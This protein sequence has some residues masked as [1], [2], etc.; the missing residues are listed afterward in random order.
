VLKKVTLMMDNTDPTTWTDH[1]VED[2]CAFLSTK[3]ETFPES[4]R[5][6]HG[7]VSALTDVTPAPNKQ[8]IDALQALP[9]PFYVVVYPAGPVGWAIGIGLVL[10]AAT[11]FLIPTPDIPTAAPALA[12]NSQAPSPNNELS[13]RTNQARINGRIPDIYGTVRSTPDLIAAPYKIFEANREIE[14]AYMCVGRGAYVINAADIRDGETKVEDIPG[15]SVM[16]YA[17]YTSPNS[18]DPN[19]PANTS[20][21][22]TVGEFVQVPVLNTKRSNSINGQV[23][24]PP[25]AGLFTADGNVRFRYPNIIELQ[26]GSPLNFTQEF[27]PGA[28]LTITDGDMSTLDTTESTVSCRAVNNVDLVQ[29]YPGGSH[30]WNTIGG[31]LVFEGADS[32]FLSSVFVDGDPVVISSNSVTSV[33]D[34]NG[35][36]EVTAFEIDG[37]DN[38]L[39]AS[40]SVPTYLV[41]RLLNPE[42]INATWNNAAFES[43]TFWNGV[44]YNV[45]VTF[46]PPFNIN[47]NGAY[48]I[49]AV[50]QTQ[51]LLDNPSAVAS[52]WETVLSVE[53][54]TPYLSPTLSSSGTTW[55]GPYI[56]E[57]PDLIEIYCNFVAQNGLY[58]DSGTTQTA[59]VV[60]I[61]FEATPVDANDDPIGD[62]ETWTFTLTGSNTLKETVAATLKAHPASFYGR[63]SVRARRTTPADTA[64]TGTVVDEVRWRDVYSV[65]FVDATD[66]GNVTTVMSVTFATASALA[67]KDRKLNMIVQRKLPSWDGSEWSAELTGT[68]D[69][70]T[71][72]GAICRDQYIGNRSADEIDVQNFFDTADEVE[73]YFGTPR[74]RRF[75]YTFDKD[76]L[77][78]EEMVSSVAKAM[79][80]VAYRQGRLIR[81]SF[82][83]ETDNSTLL[84]NHRNK[85]PGTERRTITFG[86]NQ[87][88]DGLQ[89]TYVD[90]TDDS[91]NTIFLPL[92]YAARNPKK[93]ESIGIRSHLHAYFHAWRAW[94]RIR[95]Q[96]TVAEF[97]A[98]QE[99]DLLVINDRILVSD[100]TRPVMQEGD[101][102]EVDG[103]TLTLSQNVDLTG[104]PPY[105]IFLQLYDGTVESIAITAG[106]E[107]N[108]VI[109]GSAP[110]L[111]LVTGSEMTA[112]TT[113]IIVGANESAQRAFL[114]AE[115]SPSGK[116]T[117]KVRGV[118]YDARYYGNDLD[119]INDLVEDDGLG[120][121]GGFYPGTGN[122]FPDTAVTPADVLDGDDVFSTLSSFEVPIV[123]TLADSDSA[124]LVV[125][126]LQRR[127]NTTAPTSITLGGVAPLAL[128]HRHGA[129]NSGNGTGV[130]SHMAVA[131]FPLVGSAYDG[132]VAISWAGNTGTQRAHAIAVKNVAQTEPVMVATVNNTNQFFLTAST[133][134]NGAL[135]VAAAGLM[136]MDFGYELAKDGVYLPSADSISIGSAGA[137]LNGGVSFEESTVTASGIAIEHSDGNFGDFVDMRP[138]FALTFSPA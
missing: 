29:T 3:F 56:L 43:P 135:I 47:L 64:F 76:N 72:L 95:Y 86:A 5:I 57:D 50:T 28:I 9:G 19:D 31:A 16:V 52:D 81:L 42:S 51:I 22:L 75:M 82:E 12:R 124:Y 44:F 59:A 97:E 73:T 130:Y 66:F 121:T 13:N 69:A 88:N 128:Y 112:R 77:S 54:A 46:T 123:E 24:R 134:A 60:D 87:D 90:P 126:V 107:Q 38:A 94:N 118:N 109:L 102:L 138:G 104:D 120:R 41:V 98:T 23:L 63:C 133:V 36:Y 32:E 37:P 119:F 65:S 40:Y 70:A 8:S 103:T 21:E 136:N 10:G 2:L 68:D 55:V 79:F 129:P 117:S 35:T 20:P 71:I 45:T 106:S 93:I 33:G 83:K 30:T 105:S 100:N 96:N 92:E 6:F 91:V 4:A 34:I 122:G 18:Y 48:T 89:Y 58:K 125:T 62:P 101:V 115:K 53:E 26:E 11:Y 49:L 116:M 113:Y 78:F 108:E 61:E 25:S 67:V 131:V 137:F 80:C 111:S 110:S 39:E 85:L 14:Y 127:T 7:V 1:E 27:Q 74:C 99:A 17:P 132:S 114:V 84:F 15:S